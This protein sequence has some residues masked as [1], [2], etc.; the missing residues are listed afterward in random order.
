MSDQTYEQRKA[1]A[2]NEIKSKIRNS[3]GLLLDLGG[4][5]DDQNLRAGVIGKMKVEAYLERE[6]N[7]PNPTDLASSLW[8]LFLNL[9][10]PDPLKKS[11]HKQSVPTSLPKGS[12]SAAIYKYYEEF[13]VDWKP[14]PDDYFDN[15]IETFSLH[16][17]QNLSTS[18]FHQGSVREV[19]ELY[20]DLTSSTGK[21]FWMHC[22][23]KEASIVLSLW[24][25]ILPKV[26]TI[27]YGLGDT[28]YCRVQ[29]TIMGQE[30]LSLRPDICVFANQRDADENGPASIIIE[31]KR[32]GLR[33]LIKDDALTDSSL[34][35]QVVVDMLNGAIDFC[36]LTDYVVS[37]IFMLEDPDHEDSKP[38]GNPN[39][40]K[41]KEFQEM[42]DRIAEMETLLKETNGD[43]F[44]VFNSRRRNL[45][46]EKAK[47]EK[48]AGALKQQLMEVP[49]PIFYKILENSDKKINLI[50]ASLIHHCVNY[51][52]NQKSSAI[53]KTK[54]YKSV[55][56]KKK[57][58][59]E[60]IKI[61]SRSS[62]KSVSKPIKLVHKEMSG[63][64]WGNYA[65]DIAE[66]QGGDS[67]LSFVVAINTTRC[68]EFFPRLPRMDTDSKRLVLK[69]YDQDFIKD[70]SQTREMRKMGWSYPML[71]KLAEENFMS[72][73]HAYSLITKYNKK[74]RSEADKIFAPQVIYCGDNVI[75]WDKSCIKFG[76]HAIFM[77]EITGGG[78]ITKKSIE[79][80]INQLKLLSGLGINHG[81]IRRANFIVTPD[82]RVA[83]IDYG[84][85]N[86]SS[87]L[88]G[89][90][91]KFV[92]I[93]SE[94]S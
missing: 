24:N 35:R 56:M 59:V 26:V 8:K 80:G 77:T 3:Q 64:S 70:Y 63:N 1:S 65:N 36:I 18:I 31:G 90:I 4:I 48:R 39:S 11:L 72:E 78:R 42:N 53:D 19:D 13:S 87:T 55:F 41:Q 60:N 61:G 92:E 7:G 52:A 86:G 51:S 14:F 49:I 12:T 21:D 40:T 25:L 34:V 85:V 43:K 79:F 88:E 68:Y 91:L 6:R 81:D 82:E 10:A 83:W 69:V 66:L 9:P 29:R 33:K 47:L 2:I 17:N 45:E 23:K 32:L 38:K 75:F 67:H 46:K 27:L 71:L 76:G 54:K 28:V 16:C 44:K 15:L 93:C 84:R 5:I 74:C 37:I 89:N 20:S 57:S 73:I 58:L 62:H 30:N 94:D 50:L 22:D